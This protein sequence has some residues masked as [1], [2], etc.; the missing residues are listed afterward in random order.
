MLEGHSDEFRKR[1][2]HQCERRDGQVWIAGWLL[3]LPRA[4][5]EIGTYGVLGTSTSAWLN[6]SQSSMWAPAVLLFFKGRM[7]EENCIIFTDLASDEF[8]VGRDYDCSYVLP[9]FKDGAQSKSWYQTCYGGCSN[10]HFKIIQVSFGFWNKLTSLLQL[11][12]FCC[13]KCSLICCMTATYKEQATDRCCA[14]SCFEQVVSY[15]GN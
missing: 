4:Q 6:S 15:N 5:S 10:Q 7:V 2:E 8:T 13:S 14:F 11:T 12:I 9:I 1:R 3:M